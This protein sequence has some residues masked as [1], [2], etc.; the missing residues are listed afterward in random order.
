MLLIG[1]TYFLKMK[2]SKYRWKEFIIPDG[3]HRSKVSWLPFFKDSISYVFSFDNSAKYNFNDVDQLDV[4]KLIGFSDGGLNHH[5]NSFRLGWRY[6]IHTDRV[7]ILYYTYVDGDR[8]F[9]VLGTVPVYSIME[10]KVTCVHGSYKILID[11]KV[12]YNIAR[13]KS[14]K[15]KYKHMLW[16]YFGGN[17]RA[18]HFITIFLRWTK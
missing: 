9:G 14:I 11:R 6:D 18:P 13:S 1:L 4:N 3:K 7:S 12:E 16:P 10:C 15:C 17:R 8:D 5:K 2:L